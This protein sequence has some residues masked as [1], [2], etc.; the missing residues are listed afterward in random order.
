MGVAGGSG[1]VCLLQH[2]AEVQKE[3]GIEVVVAGF[4]SGAGLPPSTD[5][6]D[7][8]YL[9]PTGSFEMDRGALVKRIGGRAELVLGNVSKTV[10]SWQPRADAPIYDARLGFA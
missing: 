8:L 4:D 2:R 5:S 3:L 9:W 10:E 7:L 1:L 6:R